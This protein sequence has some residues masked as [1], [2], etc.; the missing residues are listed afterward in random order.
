[1]TDVLVITQGPRAGR[2][3]DLQG[4]I[5]IGALRA[6]LFVCMSRRGSNPLPASVPVSRAFA[7]T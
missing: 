6:L 1:M 5:P 7:G 3:I 4:E 2:R